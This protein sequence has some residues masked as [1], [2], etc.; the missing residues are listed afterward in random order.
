MKETAAFLVQRSR[1]SFGLPAKSHGGSVRRLGPLPSSAGRDLAKAPGVDVNQATSREV[2]PWPSSYLD[3]WPPRDLRLFEPIAVLL[4]GFSVM[5][6]GMLTSW[7][8][9]RS[10]SDRANSGQGSGVRRRLHST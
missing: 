3:P 5:A 8:R 9:S 4:L 2:T 6:F 10:L 1:L 7:L